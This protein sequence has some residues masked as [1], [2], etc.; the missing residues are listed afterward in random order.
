MCLI[1]FALDAHPDYPLVLAANRE[2]RH[3]RATA[4]MA[5]WPDDPDVLAGRD[6][7]AGGTW[8][9]LHRSGR[10]AAITN[11]REGIPTTAG[12][13]SRGD[14]TRRFLQGRMPAAEYA[15][16]VYT[17][18]AHYAGFNLLTGDAGGLWYCASIAEPRRLV[19]GVYGL[20]NGLLD[21]PWPKVVKGKAA[22]TAIINSAPAPDALLAILRDRTTPPD[23]ELPDT[24]VGL[25]VERTLGS[26]FIVG[27]E[28]GTR[29]STALLIDRSG[30]AIT[31][32]QNFGPGGSAGP[33][34][35]WRWPLATPPCG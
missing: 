3:A 31:H 32:E 29:A 14:L 2:E 18:R 30:T 10:F 4:P 21:T 19:P 26:C 25:D 1:L 12:L 8:L 5:P 34:N 20:S 16:A 7:E 6:L 35:T 28:Y 17:E 24:G 27:D 22:L 15:A 23:H 33:L 11:M 13:R 9:G